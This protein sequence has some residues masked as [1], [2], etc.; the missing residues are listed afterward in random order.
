MAVSVPARQVGTL[1]ASILVS[2]GVGE[3]VGLLVLGRRE[4]HGAGRGP[5]QRAHPPQAPMHAD[6]AAAAFLV[7]FRLLP[8]AVI[9]CPAT[10][11]HFKHRL[12]RAAL[13]CRLSALVALAT[14][15][16]YRRLSDME[17]SGVAAL[18]W[19]LLGWQAGSAAACQCAL[20]L[21]ARMPAWRAHPEPLGSCL[22]A[23][24]SLHCCLQCAVPGPW[25]CTALPPLVPCARSPQPSLPCSLPGRR[26]ALCPLQRHPLHRPH[27]QGKACLLACLFWLKV[28]Q[29][30]TKHAEQN[31]AAGS[32]AH[33]S[34][35]TA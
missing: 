4:V 11:E 2:N 15:R 26:L 19:A 33:K 22:G 28:C 13:T 5:L 12:L 31:Q 34:D 27:L 17:L 1:D 10:S 35:G 23:A 21:G 25:G 20:G 9:L 29:T 8:T 30:A 3:G 18:P 7:H 32:T 14:R 16:A 24:V 6:T